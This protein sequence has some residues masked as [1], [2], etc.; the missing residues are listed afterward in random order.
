MATSISEME[1]TVAAALAPYKGILAT[2]E[3][4]GTIGKRFKTLGV[5]SSEETRR[6]YR[7]LLL[8][9]RGLAKFIS[10]VILF[11]ETI[12]QESAAGRPL[13]KLLIAQGMVP[14]IKLHGGIVPLPGFSGEKVTQGLDRLAMST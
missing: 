7:E 6:D 13:P 14:G 1:Q 4:T 10:G 5:A 3:S 9:T 8:S 2:D 11:D 12:R